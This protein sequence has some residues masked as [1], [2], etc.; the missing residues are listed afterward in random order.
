MVSSSRARVHNRGKGRKNYLQQQTL[1]TA[2]KLRDTFH[3]ACRWWS[4]RIIVL[5]DQP[6]TVFKN[7][8]FYY[9]LLQGTNTYLTLS[10][11]N[12]ADSQII[13]FHVD[14][15]VVIALQCNIITVVCK[16]ISSFIFSKMW[17]LSCFFQVSRNSCYIQTCIVFYKQEKKQK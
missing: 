4:D 13:T 2:F 17:L 5:D 15:E 7:M 1:E 10:S 3:K 6:L 12:N 16:V 11:L 8:G 9:S 14:F